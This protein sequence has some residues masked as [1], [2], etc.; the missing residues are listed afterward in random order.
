MEIHSTITMGN[1]LGEICN[2]D[3]SDKAACWCPIRHIRCPDKIVGCEVDHSYI[4]HKSSCK[5]HT[6][7]SIF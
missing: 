7:T 3:N 1:C 6:D 2:I 4:L 5:Q